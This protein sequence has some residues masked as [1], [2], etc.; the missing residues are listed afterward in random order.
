MCRLENSNGYPTSDLP[1]PILPEVGLGLGMGKRFYPSFTQTQYITCFIRRAQFVLRIA[2]GGKV[3]FGLGVG[4][5]VLNTSGMDW[6]WVCSF[7]FCYPLIHMMHLCAT[8][9]FSK[10]T[11]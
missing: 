11:S 3:A 7:S 5:Y 10:I 4:G 2:P 9:L 8:F 1:I 6:V